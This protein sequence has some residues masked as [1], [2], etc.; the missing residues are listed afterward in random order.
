MP[1]SNLNLSKKIDKF[2]DYLEFELKYS[3]LTIRNYSHYLKRFLNFVNQEKSD[4]ISK[5]DV[6]L[7]NKYKT[8]LTGLKLSKKT[9][10][11]HLISL[12]S[13]FKWMNKRGENIMS[14]D[15]IEVPKPEPSELI[16][17]TGSDVEKLLSVPDV[18]TLQGK[19]DRA[20][21]ELFYATGLRISDLTSL[22]KNSL[23]INKN[24]I[25]LNKKVF[26]LPNRA[27]KW[28]IEYINSRKDTNNALFV[29]SKGKITR[30]TPRSVE[31]MLKKYTKI[32]N[33]P[34]NITPKAL[35]HSFAT[36]L[37][38]AGAELGSI[39]KM[40]GHKNISTTQIYTHV[41]N[42]QLHDIHETFHGRRK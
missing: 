28:I 19:R 9:T 25:K 42:K 34:N 7:I 1:N 22:L 20:I 39:Q 29:S 17:L 24:E 2:I 6:N 12:R 37:L 11:F 14:V 15:Q 8:W 36:D 41:K 21:L 23:D 35:R 5:L 16:F 13:F 32:V 26:F 3:P 10:G 33:L 4:D 38:L 30:L 31:R 27:Q 18:S 40:L